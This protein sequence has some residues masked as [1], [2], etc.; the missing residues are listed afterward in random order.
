M[1]HIYDTSTNR[2]VWGF[3]FRLQVNK[4]DPL[5]NRPPFSVFISWERINRSYAQTLLQIYE[6]ES[7]RQGF[8]YFLFLVHDDASWTFFILAVG[9]VCALLPPRA[10]VDLSLLLL[11]KIASALRQAHPHHIAVEELGR[12]QRCRHPALERKIT[13]RWW[14]FR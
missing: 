13:V 10:T 9:P 12:K 6:W 11:L 2:L 3:G 4:A 14:H 5:M 7:Q 1:T 8:P